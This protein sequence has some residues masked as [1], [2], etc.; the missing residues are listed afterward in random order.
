MMSQ[1]CTYMRIQIQV[2]SVHGTFSNSDLSDLT[3]LSLFD[4]A[5]GL[6]IS[7]ETCNDLKISSIHV[8]LSRGSYFKR[9]R[10][11]SLFSVLSSV[12]NYIIN[13]LL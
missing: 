9:R 7:E 13:R 5:I 10:S 3:Q 8:D 1:V 4:L 11:R 6:L 12:R 2:Y